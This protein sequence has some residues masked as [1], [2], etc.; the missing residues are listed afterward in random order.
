MER[1][2]FI[3]QQTWEADRKFSLTAGEEDA[4]ERFLRLAI[5]TYDFLASAGAV[6]AWVFDPSPESGV[7]PLRY[8]WKQRDGRPIEFS[9][10]LIERWENWDREYF[11]IRARSPRLELRDMMHT[12]SES[13]NAS[14]WPDGYEPHIQAWVDAGDPS[15]P[16]PFEDRHGIITVTF[17]N[18]LRELRQLCGGWLYLN[19][20]LH[21]VVFAPESEWQRMQEATDAKRRRERGESR[22]RDER[23]R[24]R[25]AQI[26]A[27]ARSDNIFW[28]ALCTWELEREEGLDD[29]ATVYV[30]DSPATSTQAVGRR[31]SP[32]KQAEHNNPPVDYSIFAEFIARVHEPHDEVIVL[33]IILSLRREMRRE[34]GLDI[35]IQ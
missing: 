25:L 35:T 23:V 32:K 1:A 8:Q 11:E 31:L 20:E 17:F 12:I 9:L 14:S 34:L 10:A 7:N 4:R 15:V 16:P 33:E 26:I 24:R 2:Q 3:E 28:N 30:L 21:R 22:A 19:H 13:H 27:M 18:R 29:L 5:D 6:P